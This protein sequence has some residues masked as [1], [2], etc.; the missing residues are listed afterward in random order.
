[1]MGI[2]ISHDAWQSSYY[3]F[4]LWRRQI[5]RVAGLGDLRTVMEYFDPEDEDDWPDGVPDGIVLTVL[6]DT[7]PKSHP[8]YPLFAMADSPGTEEGSPPPHRVPSLAHSLE[9]L[10]LRYRDQWTDDLRGAVEEY[11]AGQDRG[12][13]YIR[14]SAL[15]PLAKALERLL[16]ANSDEFDEEYRSATQ[17]FIEGCRRAHSAGEDLIAS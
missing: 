2:K 7:I 1:M 15:P 16:R 11:L 13:A 14:N 3:G 6:R 10:L 17:R 5:F 9:A 8:L 12:L 4:D